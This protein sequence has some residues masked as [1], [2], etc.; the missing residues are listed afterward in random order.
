[1]LPPPAGRSAQ[2]ERGDGQV[3]PTCGGV[4]LR[5]STLPHDPSGQHEEKSPAGV[6]GAQSD[7]IEVILHRFGLGPHREIKQ[8]FIFFFI[9]S[10]GSDAFPLIKPKSLE[11][12][13]Y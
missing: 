6:S 1:M 8:F 11:Y 12:Q 5:G 9:T 13:L 3:Q 10:D 7:F 2:E 4:Q